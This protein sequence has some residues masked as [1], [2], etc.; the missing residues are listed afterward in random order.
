[1]FQRYLWPD[2]PNRFLTGKGR[3]PRQA[4][5]DERLVVAAKR[6]RS[7]RLRDVT[8]KHVQAF[9]STLSECGLAPRTVRMMHATLRLC[10]KA[11]VEHRVIPFNPAVGVRLPRNDRREMK[12]LTPP[13]AMTFLA[14]AETEQERLIG[15]ADPVRPEVE[16]VYALLILMLM[17]GLRVGEVLGLKWSDLDGSVL[18]VQRAVT[19]GAGRRHILGPTKTSQN[20]AV[21]ISDRALK[22]LQRHRVVQAKWKLLLGGEYEDQGLIFA[23]PKGALLQAENLPHRLFRK[24]LA[25]ARLPAIRLYDL[26]HS[27]ATLL[28]AAGEHPK[29]VQERLGHSGI[30]LTLNTYSHV[31][32]GMQ[33]RATAR[34]DALLYPKSR[35]KKA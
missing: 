34:L 28:M 20:R 8:P 19:R 13:E 27:H 32:P 35:T 21:P 18:R 26:R 17:T 2:E 9:V 4:R 24:L 5:K 11:A 7:A 1:L 30:E 14:A 25:E 6:L 22:A 29:V 3:R 16:G 31:I 12:C 10:F 23:T 15:G 33:E